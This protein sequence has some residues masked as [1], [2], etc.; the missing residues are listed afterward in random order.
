M[1]KPFMMNLQ[2]FT[3]KTL[4]DLLGEE[5]Y[6][7]VIQKAGDTKIDIVSNGNWIPKDKFNQL[8]EEN[9]DL[10]SQLT[11][12]DKQLK[13][14]EGKAKGNEELE[15]QIKDLQE[16]NKQTTKGFETKIKELSITNAVKL[17]LAGQVHDTDLVAGLLDKAKIELDESGNLKGG[18]EE[19]IKTLKESK[20]FLF[21]EKQDPQ[22]T[23]FK[24]I[25]PQDGKDPN[26]QTQPGD[27]NNLQDA[28]KAYFEGGK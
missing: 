5:L 10:K 15:K 28:V 4:K 24:G 27:F 12:R 3:E 9:K 14:L 13:D 26:K 6:N 25:E 21:T 2:L 19:Q 7:Q 18:L 8:N 20:S 17:A 11:D 1:K 22:Q 23:K 16:Q